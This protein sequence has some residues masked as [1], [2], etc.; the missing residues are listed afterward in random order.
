MLPLADVTFGDLLLT[1]FEIFLF[2]VWI[3]ILFTIITDL[4]RNHEMSGWLKAVWIVLLVF[5]PYLTAL[6]YLIVYG[7]DMRER[8]L[9]AQAEAKHEADH[10]IRAAAHTSP[11]DELHKL[12]DLVEKGAL[13]EA[14]YDRAKEKLLATA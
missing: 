9:R 14:E 6:I 10:Y 7:S 1:V 2:V 5:I 8:Q 3:W 12:H 4:F 13:T 11:A